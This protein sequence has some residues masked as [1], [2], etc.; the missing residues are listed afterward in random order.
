M[1][2]NLDSAFVETIESWPLWFESHCVET[3][4]KDISDIGT[5]VHGFDDKRLVVLIVIGAASQTNLEVCPCIVVH[6]EEN[7]H[8]GSKETSDV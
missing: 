4:V 1:F 6:E 8:D 5:K 2:L 3:K 7:S